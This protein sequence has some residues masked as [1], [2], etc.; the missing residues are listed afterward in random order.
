MRAEDAFELTTWRVLP[1]VL[2]Q[3]EQVVSPRMLRLL[4][5]IV[6]QWR[7]L[8]VEVEDVD[9][10]IAR[11]AQSDA[12]CQRLQ[13][14]PGVGPIAATAMVAAAGNGAAFRKGREFSAWLGLVPH[15][16]STGAQT[17]LL[18]ITKRGNEYLRRLFIHG[19]RSVCLHVNRAQ[20]SSGQL[21]YGAEGSKTIEYRHRLHWRIS[22]PESPGRY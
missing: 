4:R 13:T 9:S 14:V 3:A 16:H 18:G 5:A 6:Q 15:Q 22:W 8:E 11:L 1:E 2:S 12:A 17:K 19:A 10:E 20:H 7:E 21:D